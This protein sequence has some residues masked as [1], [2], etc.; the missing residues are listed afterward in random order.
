MADRILTP[1]QELFISYYTNPTSATFS[2]ALQ[3]ALKAGYS[4]EYSESIT[5]KDLT[6]L[7]ESIGS[8]KLLEKAERVLNETLDVE[9]VVP[10]IGMFGPIVDKETKEPVM[11][12]D[13]HILKIKQD[14][15]KFIA[16]TVGKKKYSKKSPMEGVDG[17]PLTIKLVQYTD[18]GNDTPQVQS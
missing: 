6:W 8:M 7:S 14:S 4:Q 13:A 15:A 16:E 10:K 9:H 2:N 11:E 5:A 1:Q 12:V 18:G 3:S 17:Q